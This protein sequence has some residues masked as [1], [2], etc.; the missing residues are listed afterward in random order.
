[1]NP[2]GTGKDRVARALLDSAK[3]H[4]SYRPGVDIVE[5]TS[6]ST[7]IALACQCRALGVQLHVVMPDDQANEKRI[8]LER[9]GAKVVVVPTCAIANANHYV[10]AARKLAVQLNGIFLDQFE[11]I[12]NY[13]AHLET[14]GPEIWNQ[15]QGK[16]DAFVMSSGTGGTIAGVSR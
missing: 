15:T 12:A 14:T 5:G 4:P 9:L 11:N 10:N 6:G 3:N 13:Q 1:M 16:L 7:G 2:G 8:L